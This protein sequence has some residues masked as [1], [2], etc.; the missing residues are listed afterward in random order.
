MGPVTSQVLPHRGAGAPWELAGLPVERS[1]SRNGFQWAR[2]LDTAAHC[3][4]WRRPCRLCPDTWCSHVRPTY[5]REPS[6]TAAS[7]T[8]RI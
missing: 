8:C 1:L 7:Q 3:L 4:Q 2:A 6:C 5:Y